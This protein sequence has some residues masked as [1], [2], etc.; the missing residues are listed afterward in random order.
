MGSSWSASAAITITNSGTVALRIDASAESTN[1]TAHVMRR[2]GRTMLTTAI[3]IRW[4]YFRASRGSGSR[5]IATTAT[6]R[7]SPIPSRSA[8]SVNGG[9]VSTPILMNR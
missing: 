7:A 1:C 6:S 4:P 2:N 8:M 5:A 9:I 3:T